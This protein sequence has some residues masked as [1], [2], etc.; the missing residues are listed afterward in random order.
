MSRAFAQNEELYHTRYS[1]ISDNGYF[2]PNF[3]LEFLDGMWKFFPR[4]AFLSL[5]ATLERR[6]TLEI[7][8]HY[9]APYKP[10]LNN[11]DDRDKEANQNCIGFLDVMS[12]FVPS[13]NFLYLRATVMRKILPGIQPPP[14]GSN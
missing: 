13:K 6:I 7:W 3:D 10:N 9:I 12:I 11:F 4:Y 8:P 2:D 14:N 1:Q 5:Q